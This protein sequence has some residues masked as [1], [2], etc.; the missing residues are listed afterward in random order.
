MPNNKN[1]NNKTTPLLRGFPPAPQTNLKGKV[2]KPYVPPTRL[3]KEA[4]A[5]R[6]AAQGKGG[7][8]TRKQKGGFRRVRVQ[9]PVP[10]WNVKGVNLKKY[11]KEGE[12]YG[13]DKATGMY[14]VLIDGKIVNVESERVTF[15]NSNKGALN[16]TC[17]TCGR[18]PQKIT[19]R[20]LLSGLNKSKVKGHVEQNTFTIQAATEPVTTHG[21]A[22]CTALSMVIGKMR[23]FAHIGA[24]SDITE[25]L[26][27]IVVTMREQRAKP[28][29]VKVWTG[30]GGSS[31]NANTFLRNSPA[32]YSFENVKKILTTL[33]I[34][35]ESVDVKD[36]C[37]AEVV[38]HGA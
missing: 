17:A 30:L 23:F 10:L 22:T 6:R 14:I 26:E 36:V 25:M 24:D 8:R 38:G 5:T 9:F 34:P 20:T 18:T 3:V 33:R 2:P 28:S 16:K 13:I 11:I 35:M 7:R 37:F 31:N 32:Q 12:L 15:I 4:N 1:K 29:E 19:E 27:A 21:L